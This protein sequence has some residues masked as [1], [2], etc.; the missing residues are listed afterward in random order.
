MTQHS[1]WKPP[2]QGSTLQRIALW[3][4][5][6]SGKTTF[7]S[8][9][10][11]AVETSDLD[12]RLIGTEVASTHFLSNSTDLLLYERLFPG[13]TEAVQQFTWRLS[14]NGGQK[15]ARPAQSSTATRPADGL[16]T[17][18]V[19]DAPGI[20]Y[21][22][23]SPARQRRG[24]A[25][26]VTLGDGGRSA[27]GSGA[28]RAPDNAVIDYLVQCGG[29]LLLIDPME[30]RKSASAYR[31]LH[32]TLDNLAQRLLSSG[33]RLPHQVAVVATKFDDA[34]V[35]SYAQRYSRAQRAGFN[36]FE[37]SRPHFPRIP[38][39]HSEHF[40][41]SY[42]GESRVSRMDLFSSALGRYF[43][44]DKIR[45]F[46]TSSI[47]FYVD[48]VSGIF[49]ENDYQNTVKQ[50]DGTVQVRGDINPVNVLEPLLW[51]SGWTEGRTS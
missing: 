9:L 17:I 47:G 5:P 16:A 40:L 38:S 51:L 20:L 37:R 33:G 39:D 27:A 49:D 4:A 29:V 45:F 36:L 8:A 41:R 50:D 35:Y 42:C 3:G 10:K 25:A 44:E 2:P 19:L 13:A 28:A 30:E 11:I 21:G 48:P 6:Q 31:Y 7:L 26:N 24:G 32:S 12:L 23:G 18:A 1:D 43:Q 15:R 14:W 46:V 34:E 22:T